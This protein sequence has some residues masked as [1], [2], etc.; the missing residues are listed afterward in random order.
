M[1]ITDVLE[2]S[3][4]SERGHIQDQFYEYSEKA[5]ILSK[6]R[7]LKVDLNGVLKMFYNRMGVLLN[8]INEPFFN[9][10]LQISSI[11]ICKKYL[12]KNVSKPEPTNLL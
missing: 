8:R 6:S 4:V 5:N 3:M 1:F 11:M 12:K 10:I 2:N 9:C 7:T